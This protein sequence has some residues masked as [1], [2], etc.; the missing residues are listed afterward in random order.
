MAKRTGGSVQGV[1]KQ[2]LLI[3]QRLQKKTLPWDCLSRTP[4]SF[5]L[6]WFPGTVP[7]CTRPRFVHTSLS[8]S[9]SRFFFWPMS[10]AFTL[11]ITY[12]HCVPMVDEIPLSLSCRTDTS[13][14]PSFSPPFPPPQHHQPLPF[15]TVYGHNSEVSSGAKHD[16]EPW[17]CMV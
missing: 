11:S 15:A 12:R 14:F 8:L 6:M 5:L 10:Q 17:C 1:N 9:C 4:N 16:A 2:W 13:P 3:A 7:D